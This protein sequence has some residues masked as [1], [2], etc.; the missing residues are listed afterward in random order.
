MVA[1][2]T[3]ANKNNTMD[4]K[5][6]KNDDL[7]L[8]LDNRMAYAFDVFDTVVS[9]LV[10]SPSSIFLIVGGVAQSRKL[11]D[12][13]TVE[14]S[15]R[16]R[17]AE[18]EARNHSKTGEVSLLE[19][20]LKLQRALRW[21]DTTRDE[22][23]KIELNVE[24]NLIYPVP[25]IC[26]IIS[27]IAKLNIR[28]M[29]ISD[30]YLTADTISEILRAKNVVNGKPNC[31]VSNHYGLTKR[32]GKLFEYVLRLEKLNKGNLVFCGN[33]HLA[34]ITVPKRLG[35]S[36]RPCTQAN[37]NRYEEIL[38]T[39]AEETSGLSSLMA[40]ASRF[41]RLN[42]G[43]L[44]QRTSKIVSVASGVVAPLLTG[45]VLWLFRTARELGIE[46]LYFVSRD[47]QIMYQLAKKLK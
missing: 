30:M 19:I 10:G 23:I 12:F 2:C 16:R 22:L 42:S 18:I 25:Y 15:R 9:R 37:L 21:K 39:H 14:F 32:S 6:M 35:L 46:R 20:Y 41:V 44:D 34:D 28:H 26:Q 8:S 38:E 5:Y 13:S 24:F 33:D 1:S 27:V 7:L 4:R 11:I 3:A 40:G 29:F 43:V 17:Y 45:Y 31:Y 36:V 47:G